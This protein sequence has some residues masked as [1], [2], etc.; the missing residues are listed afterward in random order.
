[1]KVRRIILSQDYETISKWWTRR[2]TEAP[3]E[4]LLPPTGVISEMDG[5]PVACAFLYEDKAGTVAMVEWEA[6]NPDCHSPMTMIRGLN[7]VFDFFEHYARDNGIS[8]VLSWVAEGRGDGRLLERRKWLKCPGQ[9][10]E[11]MAFST[12]PQ[13]ALCPQ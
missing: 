13:E 11:L 3:R 2:G 7:Q 10:H 5:V 9:R 6:T 4:I 12:Q 8:V 1:M